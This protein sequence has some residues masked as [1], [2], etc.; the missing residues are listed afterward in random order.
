MHSGPAFLLQPTCSHLPQGSSSG[1]HDQILC[2]VSTQADWKFQIGKIEAIE[3][4]GGCPEKG[5]RAIQGLEHI[6]VLWGVTEGTPIA[7]SEEEEAQGRPYH[8]LQLPE[9]RLWQGGGQPLLPGHSSRMT[10]SC[11]REGFG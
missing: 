1:S 3:D 9:R 7:H 8:S 6:S 11:A 5:N 10:G 4:I 2:E